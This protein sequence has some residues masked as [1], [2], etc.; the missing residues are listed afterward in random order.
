MI[1]LLIQTQYLQFKENLKVYLI[2]LTLG[3]LLCGLFFCAY[4]LL[5]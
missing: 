4:L 2:L 5:S 1:G 3:G